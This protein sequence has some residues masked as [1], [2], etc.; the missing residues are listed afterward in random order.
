MFFLNG[1]KFF[2][3]RTIKSFSSSTVSLH[4]VLSYAMHVFPP[5]LQ[6]KRCAPKKAEMLDEQGRCLGDQE[7]CASPRHHD[8]GSPISRQL[9]NLLPGNISCYQYL[10]N[11]KDSSYNSIVF[12]V[13]DLWIDFLTDC[14]IH[15]LEEHEFQSDSHHYWLTR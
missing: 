10:S 12:I 7:S 6:F 2:E 4:Q 9:N 8:E 3:P 5:L 13:G 11:K 1:R 14:H 15:R